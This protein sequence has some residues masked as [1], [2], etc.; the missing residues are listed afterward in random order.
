MHY[1]IFSA[2]DTGQSQVR[3]QMFGPNL[4]VFTLKDLALKTGFSPIKNTFQTFLTFVYL[5]SMQL[6]SAHPKIFWKTF[7]NHFFVHRNFKKWA[8][9]VAHNRHRPFYF[10][11][12]PRP[13]PTVHNRFFKLWISGPDICSL[14]CV[15]IAMQW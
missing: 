11:V 10:T 12:Q 4:H 14:I 9:K 2:T 13:Q 8:S 1:C 5:Y 6:F 15:D 7:S 3:K